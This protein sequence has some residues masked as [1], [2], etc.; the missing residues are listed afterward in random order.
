M[1]AL[2]RRDSCATWPSTQTSPSRPIHSATLRATV[3]TGQ[4]DSGE[5]GLVTL[6]SLPGA[7]GAPDAAGSAGAGPPGPGQAG[8]AVSLVSRLDSSVTYGGRASVARS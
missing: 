8:A 1:A 3:R 2:P 5:D 7:G 4:G 6:P